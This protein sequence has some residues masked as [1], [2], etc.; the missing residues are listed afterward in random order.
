MTNYVLY[1]YDNPSS[2]AYN[3]SIDL[4]F[5]FKVGFYEFIVRTVGCNAENVIRHSE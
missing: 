3:L 5:F 2:H 4:L 1:V